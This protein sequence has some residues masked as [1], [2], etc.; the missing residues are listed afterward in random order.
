MTVTLQPP[1]QRRKT[2]EDLKRIERVGKQIVQ[3]M[4]VLD[5]DDETAIFALLNAAALVGHHYIAH[6][7]DPPAIHQ[8]L[9]RGLEVVQRHWARAA[10]S[11]GVESKPAMLPAYLASTSVN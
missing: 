9:M 6:Q 1:V 8:A 10:E 2:A 11:E 3:S 7:A 4:I 5:V